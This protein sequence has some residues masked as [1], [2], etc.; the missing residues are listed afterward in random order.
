MTRWIV[1]EDDL[2]AARLERR[3]WS[4]VGCLRDGDCVIL[5]WRKLLGLCRLVDGVLKVLEIDGRELCEV[6]HIRLLEILIRI[7]SDDVFDIQEVD[8]Q[9]ITVE[10]GECWS[11]NQIGL[12]DLKDVVVVHMKGST[13]LLAVVYSASGVGRCVHH[14]TDAIPHESTGVTVGIVLLELVGVVVGVVYHHR[15]LM[16]LRVLADSAER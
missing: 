4:V 6:L 12:V 13:R 10:L 9:I 7:G 3:N 1:V 11:L 8:I 5:I 15:R 16:L 14:G 2:T